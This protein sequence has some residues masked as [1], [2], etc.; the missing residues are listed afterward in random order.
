MEM[1]L[2]WLGTLA[3]HARKRD[4]VT[5]STVHKIKGAER[6]VIDLGP[7]SRGKSQREQLEEASQ[8]IETL[9][10]VRIEVEQ[11]DA[12]LNV[13]G[14]LVTERTRVSAIS[15]VLERRYRGDESVQALAETCDRL[16]RG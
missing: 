2:D 16:V 9:Q 1:P 13:V 10:T 5:I 7:T 12:L 8:K 14:E 15:R 11:L 4:A 6:R 3:A